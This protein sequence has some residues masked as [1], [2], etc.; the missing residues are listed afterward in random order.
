MWKLQRDYSSPAQVRKAIEGHA[1]RVEWQLHRIYRARNN[2]V[3]AGRRLSFLDAL[4][5][6]LDEYFRVSFGT[7]VNR[8]AKEPTASDIDEIVADI[9]LDY[10]MYTKTVA[11]LQK[12]PTLTLELLHKLV[13]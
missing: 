8:A 7:I 6:N 2:L 1:K 3:H 12:E 9:G 10:R 4:V 13:H 5:L 11:A